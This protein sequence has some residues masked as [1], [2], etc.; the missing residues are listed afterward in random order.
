MTRNF[1]I[2]LNIGIISSLINDR[3]KLRKCLIFLMEHPVSCQFKNIK[4]ML[5]CN[6]WPTH[7]NG[8][9]F[10]SCKRNFCC[11]ILT[12]LQKLSKCEVK[13]WL[14]WNLIILLP[15]RFYVKWN[16]G[17]FKKSK[18]VIFGNLETLNF[19]IW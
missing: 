11:C 8:W 18:N 1:I 15:P 13:A 3:K 19:E 7:T 12:M 6:K 5:L 17:K 4:N 10:S 9:N 14:C 2:A 16:F